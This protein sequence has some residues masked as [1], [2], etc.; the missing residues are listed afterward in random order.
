MTRAAKRAK[1]SP[2]PQAIEES[3]GA[4]YDDEPEP[5]QPSQRRPIVVC[6]KCRHVSG[7]DG[8]PANQILRCDE[9]GTR[10]AFG[11]AQPRMT[12]S[13]AREGDERRILI[14]M[15][16]TKHFLTDDQ[17]VAVADGI[18]RRPVLAEDERLQQVTVEGATYTLD[19][20]WARALVDNIMSIARPSKT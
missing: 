18:V 3:H 2:A 5:T 8:D 10:I 4:P 9:C 13:P 7:F 11:V 1:P 20:A 19:H 12:I 6:P 15:G 16:A 17:A 14:Q